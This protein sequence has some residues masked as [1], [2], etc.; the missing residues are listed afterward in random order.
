MNFQLEQR[1]IEAIR[2]LQR[3]DSPDILA[4]LVTIYLDK[5]PSL[6]GDIQA[7]V[8]AN[9]TDQVKLAAHTLKSSSAYLGATTL[10]DQCGKLEQKA[11]RNDL[12]K[13]GKHLD[14]IAAGFDAVSEQIRQYG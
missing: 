12:S 3:P 14:A 4:R 7:G 6:I 1:A 11:A 5:S 8:L 9:D 2:L 10:A 13:A